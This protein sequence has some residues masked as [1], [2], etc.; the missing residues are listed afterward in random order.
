MK[1]FALA[2]VAVTGILALAGC[3]LSS[4]T[5]AEPLVVRVPL[6]APGEDAQAVLTAV[7]DRVRAL[8]ASNRTD[9]VV[10]ELAPGVW[11]LKKGLK[12]GP[13]DSGTET[14]PVVWRGA[15]DGKTVL[16]MSREIPIS[17]FRPVTDAAALKRLDKGAA[18]GIR[19]ADVSGFG[20]KAPN[21]KGESTLQPL[22]IPEVYFDG[23]R[24]PFARWPNSGVADAGQPQAWTTIEKIL[25]PGGARSTG[26][27]FDAAKMQKKAQDPTGGVFRYSGNRPSRWTTAPEVYLQGF[28][29]FDWWESTI[30]VARIDTAT[31]TIALKFPHIY[32][33]KQGNPSPRR[34]RAVHLLEEL[35]VP[36][37]YCFDFAAQRLYF[38]PPRPNGRVSVAGTRGVFFALDGVHDLAVENLTVEEG[39]GDGFYGNNVRR[40]RVE[41]VCCR[42]LYNKAL[43]FQGAEDCV[44]RRCDVEEMGRGGLAVSGGDRKTLRSGNN[45]I[46]DCRIRRYS[47]LQFCYANGISVGGV[48]ATVRHNEITDAPHQAV[49]WGCNDGLFEYNLV[50]NVVNCSDDAGA[51]YKGR[52]PSIRGNVIRNNLWVDIGSAR[53]HGTA[54]IYFDDGDVGELVEGN[55]FIRCGQPGRG[56]FGTVFCHGGFSNVVRNCV[57]ID[58]RR[59]FGSAP[60]NDKRWREYVM[61][62]L[63]QQRL[64]KDVDITKAPYLTRYPDFAGFM[65]PQP[66]QAR[67]NLAVSNVI[68]N[69]TSVKSGRFVTNETDVVYAADPGIRPFPVGKA[70]LLT[71]RPQPVPYRIDVKPGESLTAVRDRVRSL[72]GEARAHGIEIVLASGD[73]FVGDGLTLQGEDSGISFDAPVV[74]RAA[75][76]GK[77]RLVGARRVPSERFKK[78]TDKAILDRLPPEG[79]DKVLAADISDLIPGK[80]PQLANSFT[81]AP[82]A[83]MVFV[84]G[85]FATLARWPNEGWASFT[86]RV[87]KGTQLSK[88]KYPGSFKDGAFVFSDPRAKRWDF[89]KG[90]WL[91]GY[92]THDWYNNSIKARS[93]GVENGTND[94]IRLDGA[95]TYGVMGG[96]WGRKDRRFRAFNLLEELDAPGEWWMDRERKILY[97]VPPKG[98]L[99][100][101]DEVMVALS[102]K[103]LLSASGIRFVRFEGLG[104]AYGFGSLASVADN[105]SDVT[106]SGCR[107]AN[108]GRVGLRLTGTRLTARDCE[109]F[110]CG[111]S[112]ITLYGGDR[113]TLTRSDSL[114]ENCR[115]H[116]F[117][118]FQR[119]YAPGIQVDGCGMTLRGNELWD[120]PH[121]AVLYGGNEHLFESNDVHHVLMET[122]DAGAFY[123]GRDWT[124]MGTVLRY[125]FVHELGAQG[126]EANTMGFYFDD[127]DCGDAVYGNVFWKVAR[128]IMVGGGREHPIRHNVFAECQVGLSID[129]RGMTW[130]TWNTPGNGWNLEEKAKNLGYQSE[131]WKSRYPLLAKI[132]QDSPKEPLYDPVTDNVFL[133]CTE[134]LVALS[135]K[136]MDP[137]I[138]KMVFSNNLVFVSSPAKKSAAPDKRIEKAFLMM[139]NAVDAGFVDAA[140]GDFRLKP[141]SPIRKHLPGFPSR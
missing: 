7:R 49:A 136:S 83:P 104:F 28:W 67:D 127:C 5:A 106:F 88:E 118:V 77:A 139:T 86:Q 87:D 132:M 85:D 89:A 19:W 52:N 115:I 131:P 1:K 31:N 61:A 92:W 124:T 55:V 56:S 57:F 110:N 23:E 105:S 37:E 96:T 111:A 100:P 65:D 29:A 10:I 113:K 73:Y 3:F 13:E 16:R 114:V 137:V 134:Q 59:P 17:A 36:G 66:G 82:A 141:D 101:D 14:A 130:K 27:A 122:G 119:T 116:G 35:D 75:E 138:P 54:A 129:N 112:G 90:V 40:V 60:W 39:F 128:G 84:G 21:L 125:N 42:K 15:A 74:W 117:G 76:P 79:R 8:P 9:G 26:S 33:V 126:K 78:V 69:C 58:C 102:D 68:V 24:M 98:S 97:L 93:Y 81:G 71:P 64:L 46:E 108:V 12:F 140:R 32:G 22:A 103:T 44:I 47:R 94:V 41:G 45:L 123:T 48:G 109:V 6:P 121:A 133:D 50:S 80:V 34:W 70:G 51:F 135:G 30:P 2:G 38:Y 72:P 20:F 4:Q 11:N 91:N 18:K 107:F 62:P 63:W 120:A 43:C 95:M 25:S 53:G 99:G